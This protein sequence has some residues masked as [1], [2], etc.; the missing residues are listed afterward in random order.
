MAVLFTSASRNTQ[1]TGSRRNLAID[2]LQAASP[3]ASRT[4]QG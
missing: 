3:F 2:T 4:R 1:V